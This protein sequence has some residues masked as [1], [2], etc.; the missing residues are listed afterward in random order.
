ME[1]TVRAKDY[2]FLHAADCSL[3]AEV[4]FSDTACLDLK[5]ELNHRSF[6]LGENLLL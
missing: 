4:L 2:N 3:T 1:R 5:T 6:C